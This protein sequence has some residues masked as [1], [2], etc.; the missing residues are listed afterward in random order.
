MPE[1]NQI[2]PWFQPGIQANPQIQQNNLTKNQQIIPQNN[3]E[4]TEKSLPQNLRS[5]SSWSNKILGWLFIFLWFILNGFWIYAMYCL[6]SDWYN[7]I[8]DIFTNSLVSFPILAWVCFTIIWI[9]NLFHDQKSH[10]SRLVKIVSCIFWFLWIALIWFW[11]YWIFE[12]QSDLY[13]SEYSL[14]DIIKYSL[15]RI[16]G[17]LWIWF[18]ILWIL[19]YRTPNVDIYYHP[20]RLTKIFSG[21]YRFLW[22]ALIRAGLWNFSL[23]WT[24]NLSFLKILYVWWVIT[25]CGILYIF[26]WR[27]LYNTK[28]KAHLWF[29]LLLSL[30]A[31][32]MSYRILKEFSDIWDK[33]DGN[34]FFIIIT[35][36]SL[37]Y[38]SVLTIRWIIKC[39]KFNKKWIINPKYLN[40]T[41]SKK[42]VWIITTI[43]LF[44]L[45]IVN[46]I[47]GKIQWSK[48]PEIDT[49]I[50]A[51]EK[52]Q[53]Q[54]PDEE[55]AL[56]QLKKNYSLWYTNDIWEA[57]EILYFSEND[58][59][60]QIQNSW[61]R[62]QSRCIIVYSWNET[63]CGTWT[64]DKKTLNKFFNS[65]YTNYP[66]I[67]FWNK[68]KDYDYFVID[69]KKVTI[70]EYLN[71][72]EPKIRADLQKLDK[73]ASLEYNLNFPS[74]RDDPYYLLPQFLQWYSRASMVAL[75]YYTL[76]EDWDMV[77]FIIKLNYKIIDILN[78]YWW[79][80]PHLISFVIQNVTD[81]NI[82]SLI[83]L[84]P[85]DFR[86]QL[87]ERYS[88]LNY[89]K[90]W[91]LKERIKWEYNI[92][93]EN[94]A[95]DRIFM[96][97]WSDIP[98]LTQFLFHFPFLSKKDSN[99]FMEYAYYNLM[100]D[101]RFDF[102][103][104]QLILPKSSLYNYYWNYPYQALRPRVSTYNNRLKYSLFHKQALIDNLRTWKYQT[105]FNELEWSENPNL[106]N[107]NRI[108]T[109]EEFSEWWFN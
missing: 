106:Y 14:R 94:R 50:F 54:L 79:V 46:L 101:E 40:Q 102:D 23:I 33:L 34:L 18:I 44:L 6:M 20:T 58:L 43:V 85:K 77:V 30:V 88:N 8:W 17:P 13:Y 96:D 60:F 4:S 73:I 39:L 90:E 65:F 7:S 99:R 48:I 103:S 11:V 15:F 59:N 37:F 68:E 69:W 47:Y 75:Q 1:D 91:M 52:H 3:T 108:P 105:W 83:K 87:S 64:R 81:S 74:S 24:E 10:T 25:L 53:T 2:Q 28:S 84:F 89:D 51:R 66:Y 61:K 21:I 49:S 80:A 32:I 27:L 98:S 78:N 22:I 76:K 31:N 104:V 86:I 82:N 12:T 109:D 41:P 95:K 36:F 42:K 63:S 72:N 38:F 92:I 56:I 62:Y 9:R 26:L 70:L 67:S 57:L 45:I 16:L 19:S 71:K 107:D 97:V 5:S 55:D 100:R 93:W 29:S 35:L